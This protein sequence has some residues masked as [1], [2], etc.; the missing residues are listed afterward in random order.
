MNVEIADAWVIA[1]PPGAGKTTVASVL[2]SLLSPV[3]ALLDKD[4]MYGGFVAATLS[5]ADRPSGEREGPWYDEHVKIHEYGGMTAVAQEIRS[6]GCP[7]MLSAPFTKHIHDAGMWHSW[8]NELGG[9]SVR[10]VWVRSDADSL[11]QRLE[12]RQS[13][14]DTEKLAKFDAFI[15]GMHLDAEPAVEH[16]TIDNRLSAT[17]TIEAQLRAVL[18]V[19]LTS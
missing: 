12:T 7:V 14:R 2:L 1:G 11:R 15:A 3:P 5:A 4:N 19:H 18:G 8:V 17:L 16:V 9:G 10:L 13:E 6:K